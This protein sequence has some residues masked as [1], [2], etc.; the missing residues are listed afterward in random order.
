LVAALLF[1]GLAGA[2]GLAVNLFETLRG[3]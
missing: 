2:A 1:I 3:I